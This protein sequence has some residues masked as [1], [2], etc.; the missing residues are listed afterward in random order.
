[1]QY[2]N[3]KEFKN[4]GYF[5]LNGPIKESFFSFPLSTRKKTEHI[6]FSPVVVPSKMTLISK[7]ILQFVIK[8]VAPFWTYSFTDADQKYSVLEFKDIVKNF[9]SFLRK[10]KENTEFK[11]TFHLMS[12]YKDTF[13]IIKAFP[14]PYQSVGKAIL[15]NGSVS[16]CEILN[17]WNT[18][19]TSV[20]H[21]DI[22][23]Y[24]G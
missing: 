3:N 16:L 21:I 10:A 12:Y 18:I 2:R 7:E 1:M 22:D 11:K 14:E 9:F 13:E 5:I 15:K 8:K 24:S 6:F 19:L 4:L 17:I 20:H 23:W